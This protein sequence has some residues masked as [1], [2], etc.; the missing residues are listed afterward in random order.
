MSAAP[1]D[2]ETLSAQWGARFKLLQRHVR[3]PE[4][5]RFFGQPIGTPIERDYDA[6]QYAPGRWA[7]KSIE[8]MVHDVVEDHIAN[9][10]Y[11]RANRDRAARRLPRLTPRAY[12]EH[13]TKV[14]TEQLRD[15]EHDPGRGGTASPPVEY[16]RLVVNGPALIEFDIRRTSPEDVARVAAELDRLI[17]TYPPEHRSRAIKI[18]IRPRLPGEDASSPS[19]SKS[20]LGDSKIYLAEKLFTPE[21]KSEA[22]RAMPS[23]DQDDPLPYVMAHEWGHLVAHGRI[24]SSAAYQRLGNLAITKRA[25][26]VYAIEG[27]D[28]AFAEA[29]AEWDRTNGRTTNPLVHQYAEAFPTVFRRL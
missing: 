7:Y 23:F 16:R 29:L 28:E 11:E 13:M 4:G 18:F 19:L 15:T 26:S 27:Y 22:K 14:L 10:T 1:A 2:I 20:V 3:T 25:L 24:R 6:G 21:A 8:E 17:A 5:S 12:R 9:G